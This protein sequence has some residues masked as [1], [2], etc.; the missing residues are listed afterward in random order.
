LDPEDFYVRER[1]QLIT[2]TT[3]VLLDLSWSMS[4]Y[5]RFESAKKVALALDHF[6]RTRFPKD[7]LHVVGFSTEARELKGSEL[8][9]A[10]WDTV[11]PFTNL[12]AALRLAM[13][14][15]KKSGNRNNRV[16]VI[17]DG[18][19][20]AYYIGDQLHVELPEDMLGLSPNAAKA[21]LVEVQKVT[22]QGMNIETFMLDN[23]P[24]LVEFTH[25]ISK[26]NGGRAVMCVPGKLG[27]L[28]LIEEIKRRGGRI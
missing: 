27:E 26:I 20:T 12:Q 10:V 8:A 15:I 16:I 1:E 4:W 2:S 7:K 11:Q 28:I 25:A 14:L 9:L 19:P 17:T 5:G 6:I 24:V 23:N 3:V 22:A 21:T 18:Q 13:Q